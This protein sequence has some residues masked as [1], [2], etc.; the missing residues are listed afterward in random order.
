MANPQGYAA[1]P[2]LAMG[3]VKDFTN[4]AVVP[5]TSIS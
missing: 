5:E 3:I 4:R 1:P 2:T